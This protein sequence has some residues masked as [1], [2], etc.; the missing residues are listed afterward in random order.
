MAV[1]ASYEVTVTDQTDAKDLI[2]WYQ[3]SASAT[4]PNKPTTTSASATPSGWTKAEPS[5]DP[6]QGTKYLYTC[7]QLVWGDG[8]CGWGDVQ[9][10][11]SYEAAKSAVNAAASAS[12]S[13]AS[14]AEAIG[15]VEAPYTEV[16]WV[17]SNGTQFVYLDWKPPINTWGFEADFIIRNA[18]NTT[19]AKWNEEEN[20][21][22]VGFLFG[23]RNA[24]GV[25]DIELGSY[26][27]SGFLRIGN[28]T[29]VATGM[30]TDKTR[31]TIKLIGT[32]LTKPNGTTATVTRVNETANKPYC[33]MAVFAYHEGLRRG[34]TGYLLYPSTSRIYSLKFYEDTT[35]KV[36]LVGA[37][38]NRDGM[39]GL[40]DKVAD[41]FYPAANMT[42]GDAVGPLG[43]TSTLVQAVAKSQIVTYVDNRAITRMWHATIPEL[44]K[45]EDG[46]KITVIFSSGVSG[47]KPADAGLVGWDETA[48]SSYSNVFLKLTLADGSETEWVPCYYSNGTRLT[49]HYASGTPVL[50][51][52]REN[53][54]YNATTASAGT[55]VMRGWWADPNYVDGN[56][57]YTKYSDTVIAGK[58]GLKVYTLCMK[59]DEDNWTTI[60]NQSST[61]SS[62]KTCYTGGLKLGNV[63]YHATN[64]NYAAGANGG[65]MWETYGGIDFRRD[66]NGITDKQATTELQL[67][68]P[69]YFVGTI[70]DDGLF[71]L[72]TTKWWTQD[73][74][75]GS[76]VYVLVGS[77]YS[78]Y[79]AIF[80]AA[81]NPT[82]VVRDGELVEITDSRFV[83]VNA[84]LER[85]DGV[86]RLKADAE[87]VYTKQ[88]ANAL[89]EVKANKATLTSEINASADTVKIDASRVN[90]TGEAVFSAINNDTGTTKINGG[91]IDA[92]GIT[93]GQRTYV[94]I[95]ATAINFLANTATLEAT[96]FV[97]GTAKTSGV[98]YAWLKDGS[99]ISG[100]TGRTYSVTASSGLSHA[101]SCKCTWT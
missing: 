88:A 67:R 34:G 38:R 37:I 36:H 70:H 93:I 15:I 54:F 92:T 48:T 78:S 49:T 52:Y 72:D 74:N 24:S 28:A 22:N 75:D 68:K 71:Y 1:K 40:Y 16:E 45:L 69:I 14:V 39:T 20:V 8:T 30:K 59:D 90:I 79:N 95:R 89:L 31:Q 11:S 87:N 6:S 12:A 85:Q 43:E 56:T 13:A 2:T 21:N 99:A 94:S 23:T 50:L 29:A 33:N 9:L 42:H 66:A 86:I 82:Y 101:Y 100:A 62:D 80:L 7:Q 32:T 41:H 18:F 5:Y 76:K 98:T 63:L 84:E 64:G 17:E 91:K 77:A 44:D 57:T 10:S 58:N 25:N 47:S 60:V 61:G 51:T 27:A 3:L 96:L 73:P 26:S 65:Q 4:K 35:V 83:E 97:D 19:Q 55:A 53:V 81:D 46:Q